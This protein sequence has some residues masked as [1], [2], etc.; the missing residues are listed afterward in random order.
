[1]LGFATPYGYMIAALLVEL[2]DLLR[3]SLRMMPAI[4]NRHLSQSIG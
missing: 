1:V 2:D 3:S 4:T